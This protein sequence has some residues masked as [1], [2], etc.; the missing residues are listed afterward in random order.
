MKVFRLIPNFY[1]LISGPANQ[2]FNI[3]NELEKNKI[4]SPILTSDFGV[5]NAKFTE[6]YINVNCIRFK[7]LF[8][9]FQY[10]FTPRFCKIFLR[11]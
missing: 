4:K 9:I 11:G 5:R 6:K 2:A 1:P 10:S 8:N 7:S 3:S